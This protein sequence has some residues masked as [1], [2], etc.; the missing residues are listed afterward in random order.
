VRRW[1]RGVGGPARRSV[2]NGPR[3]AR[4]AWPCRAAGLNRSGGGTLIGGV[5]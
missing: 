1:G 5:G 2:D 4:A 3:P